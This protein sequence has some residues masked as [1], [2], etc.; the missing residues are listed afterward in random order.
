[1]NPRDNRFQTSRVLRG[2]ELVAMNSKHDRKRLADGAE[3]GEADHSLAELAEE[4][5]V[6]FPRVQ[7]RPVLREG[8]HDDLLSA[9]RSR[10]T[11][12]VVSPWE[13]RRWLFIAGATVGSLVP[14][15]GVLAYFVCSRLMGKLRPAASQ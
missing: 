5:T 9:M 11:L 8:L 14:L 3:E 2:V 10:G 13:R 12:R 1:V 7:P 4:V 15:C 6:V